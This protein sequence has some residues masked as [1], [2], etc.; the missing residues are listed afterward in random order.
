MSIEI[1]ETENTNAIILDGDY[2]DLTSAETVQGDD[3]DALLSGL[4]LD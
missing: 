2:I 1:I 4:N 3:L